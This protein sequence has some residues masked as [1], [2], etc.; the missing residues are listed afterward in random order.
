MI[1]VSELAANDRAAHYR[2][3]AA[4]ARREGDMAQSALRA[5][6]LVI[7]EQWERLALAAEADSTRKS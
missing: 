6:Y 1:D 5:S 3:L 4:G 2:K 7:S